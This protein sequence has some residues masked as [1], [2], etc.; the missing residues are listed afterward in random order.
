MFPCSLNQESRSLLRYD[1]LLL[2]GSLDPRPKPP[3][4]G[5]LQFS[6]VQVLQF[7]DFTSPHISSILLTSLL[8]TGSRFLLAHV[9]QVQSIPLKSSPIQS[10]Q[11]SRNDVISLPAFCIRFCFSILRFVSGRDFLELFQDILTVT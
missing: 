5:D 8:F 1:S 7:L 4:L 9:L 10:L 3:G 2:N 6:L 11:S